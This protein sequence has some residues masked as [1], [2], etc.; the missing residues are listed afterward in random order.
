MISRNTKGWGPY[1][2]FAG[3][4]LHDGHAT[5][6]GHP[7]HRSRE[8][9]LLVKALDAHYPPGCV[10]RLV[11]DNHSSPIQGVVRQVLR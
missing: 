11:L 6:E 1:P 5:A 4:D 2:F 10:I 7:R 3:L 9:I 8:F